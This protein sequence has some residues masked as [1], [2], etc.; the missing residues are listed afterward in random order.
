MI[1][2]VVLITNN[3]DKNINKSAAPTYERLLL[4]YVIS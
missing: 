3:I 1:L 4:F 2:G